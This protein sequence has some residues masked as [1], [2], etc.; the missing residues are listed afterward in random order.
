MKQKSERSIALVVT[1][2]RPGLEEKA[3]KYWYAQSS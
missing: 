1:K 2:V 3:A